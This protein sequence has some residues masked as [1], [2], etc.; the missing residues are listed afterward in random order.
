MMGRSVEGPRQLLTTPPLHTR[1]HAKGQDQRAPAPPGELT[2]AF[3]F[4]TVTQQP[5]PG[6]VKADAPCAWRLRSVKELTVL[7]VGRAL[8]RHQL[9]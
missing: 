6:D 4:A 7:A 5:D 1:S 3:G 8:A 2:T 9:L